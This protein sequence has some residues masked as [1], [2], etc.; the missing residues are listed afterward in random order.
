MK[1]IMVGVSLPQFTDDPHKLIDG[2]RRAEAAGLDS[3]WVFDHLWPFGGPHERPV[4]ECWSTLAWLAAITESIRIGTLVTRSSLRHPALLAKMA[5]TVGEIAPGRLTVGIGSGD[6][7]SRAENE[8][9]GIPYY[10]GDERIDQL[11]S[12]VKLLRRYLNEV[13]VSHHD[14]FASI[15]SLPASPR[16]D[17]PPLIWVG[18]RSEQVLEVAGTNADGWNGWGGTPEVFAADSQLVLEYA[19]DRAVELSWGGQVIFGDT[20]RDAADNLGSR[21][22]KHYLVGAPE[23]VAAKLLRFVE[24]GARHVIIGFPNAATPGVY[25]TLAEVVVPILEA[26]ATPAPRGAAG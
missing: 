26:A 12:T 9:F 8:A 25:E 6:H 2:V 14:D 7:L 15:D 5:A 16:P 19:R 22:P 17:P 10:P 18:G 1:Q 20:D 11:V 21:N 13:R 24:A 4:F 3:I 23:T